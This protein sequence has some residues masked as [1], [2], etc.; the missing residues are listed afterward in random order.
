MIEIRVC[1]AEPLGRAGIENHTI[2][3]DGKIPQRKELTSLNEVERFY[4]KQAEMI[5]NVL[6]DSLPQGVY[7]R[8][9]IM[10]MQSKVSLYQG[11]TET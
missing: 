5:N 8:L 4:E 7:D 3:I 1:K 9:G 10:F 2:I 11:K 6:T